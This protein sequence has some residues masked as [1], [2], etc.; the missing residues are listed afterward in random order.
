MN[1]MAHLSALVSLLWLSLSYSITTLNETELGVAILILF[2][3]F[4]PL[5]IKAVGDDIGEFNRRRRG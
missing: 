1:T 2:F 4:I 5:T 3:T